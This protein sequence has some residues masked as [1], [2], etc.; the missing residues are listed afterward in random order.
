MV[1]AWATRSLV[2]RVSKW[3][4][5]PLPRRSQIARSVCRGRFKSRRRRKVA[6]A[7]LGRAR[8]DRRDEA[9]LTLEVGAPIPR[10]S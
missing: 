5:Y 8:R 4:S 2:R 10:S 1:E 7:K 6:M 9:A 3:R